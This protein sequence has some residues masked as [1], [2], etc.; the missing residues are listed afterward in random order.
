MKKIVWLLCLLFFMGGL[1]YGDY[2]IKEKSH[3]DAI[4]MMGQSQPARDEVMEMWISQDLKKMAANSSEQSNDESNG[5]F[6]YHRGYSDRAEKE[7]WAMG[8]F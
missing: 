3:T 8:V 4:Q 5:Q 2:F 7:N 6:G 1:I